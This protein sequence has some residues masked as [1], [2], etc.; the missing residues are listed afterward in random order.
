MGGFLNDLFGNATDTSTDSTLAMNSMASSA[1]AA[2]A[3]LNAALASTTPEVRRL[4][5]EYATQSTMAN[6]AVTELAVSR[7]WINPYDC[8]ETQLQTS[9]DK[10]QAAMGK[11]QQS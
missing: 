10:A 7:K 9:I 6:E 8:P 4:F 11:S 5:S 2:T 3:Y 1:A